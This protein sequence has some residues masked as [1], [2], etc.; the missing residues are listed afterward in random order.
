MWAGALAGRSPPP[1]VELWVPYDRT[2]GVY[3]RQGS[4]K[5]L[6]LLTPALLAAPG[7]SLVTLTKLDDLLLTLDE[8]RSGV[9]RSGGHNGP[10]RTD[11]MA[12]VVPGFRPG[13]WRPARGR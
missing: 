6:D 5:T 2:A 11:R 9:P 1:G 10:R 8:R 12:A 13:A 7:A 4:G 3:G